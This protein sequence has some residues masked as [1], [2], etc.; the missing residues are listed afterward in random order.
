MT[1]QQE[2]DRK[3]PFIPLERGQK[4]IEGNKPKGKKIKYCPGTLTHEPYLEPHYHPMVDANNHSAEPYPR[5]M[6]AEIAWYLSQH[7]FLP[8]MVLQVHI[9][10]KQGEKRTPSLDRVVEHCVDK[11]CRDGYVQAIGENAYQISPRLKGM[12]E[13]EG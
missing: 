12:L 5:S 7:K 4:W 2:L 6:W 11:L 1:T 3:I 10:K 8:L 9:A 13:N